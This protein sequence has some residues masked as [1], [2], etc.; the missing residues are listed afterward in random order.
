MDLTYNRNLAILKRLSNLNFFR[1]S[2]TK[3]KV[4]LKNSTFEGIML[5]NS[6]GSIT[7]EFKSKIF[8]LYLFTTTLYISYQNCIR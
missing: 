3:F 7:K 6:N 1:L 4:T 5:R 8:E 2:A